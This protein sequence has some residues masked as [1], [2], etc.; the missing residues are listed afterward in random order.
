MVRGVFM[1]TIIMLG[2]FILGILGIVCFAAYKIKAAAARRPRKGDPMWP[3][4]RDPLLGSCRSGRPRL[5][6]RR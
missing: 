3:L 6:G 5:P 4:R 1:A 2:I